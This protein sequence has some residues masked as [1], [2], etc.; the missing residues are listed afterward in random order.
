MTRMGLGVRLIIRLA[1]VAYH[2][3]VPRA[4]AGEWL[5]AGPVGSDGGVPGQPPVRPLRAAGA[6]ASAAFGTRDNSGRV[7]IL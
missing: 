3:W 4:L 2:D 7:H 6:M 5:G 1:H